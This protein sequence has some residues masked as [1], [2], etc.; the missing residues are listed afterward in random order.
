V[1]ELSRVTKVY[2]ADGVAV[3]ALREVDLHIAEG[4]FVALMGP[5]GSGKSTL[6]TILGAM[7]PPTTGRVVIDG[8]E[9]YN[10]PLE[11]QADFRHEYVGFV[12]QQYHLIPY[13]TVLENVLLPLTIAQRPRQEKLHQA[14]A[15]IERVGLG[16]KENRLPSQLSGGEQARVT[17]ARALVNQP[18]LLLLDEPTGNLDSSTGARVMELL[19]ELNRAG[20]AV[21]MVTHN[22]E[23]AACA[24]RI[25]RLR[26][27]CI[28][29][30][31]AR[32]K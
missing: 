8:I 2:Q 6:L 9:P 28:E 3:H 25:I 22:P 31:T 5:S 12:F 24:G 1:I 20:Q 21:V 11:R 26:D 17:I 10:L 29:G 16:G 14:K 7:N 30:M 32:A 18:P 15:A 23:T 19:V 27:G 4:E 13:L